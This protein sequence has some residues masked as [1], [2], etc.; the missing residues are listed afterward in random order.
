MNALFGVLFIIGLIVFR[1]GFKVSKEEAGRGAAITI[2]GFLLLLPSLGNYMWDLEQAKKRLPHRSGFAEAAE[3]EEFFSK[4]T[5]LDR[6]VRLL[7]KQD[8]LTKL[9]AKLAA[10]YHSLDD[11]RQK[12]GTESDA[13]VS[14]FNEEVAAYVS[15]RDVAGDLSAEIKKLQG[16]GTK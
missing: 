5:D 6:E 11:R 3:Q 10:W 14:K 15:L 4:Q 9:N 1:W 2:V 8:V 16:D 12:L 13:E 7:A